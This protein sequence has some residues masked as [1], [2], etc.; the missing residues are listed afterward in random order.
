LNVAAPLP[1]SVERQVDR[2]LAEGSTKGATRLRPERRPYWRSVA[3]SGGAAAAATLIA[4]FLLF[5][6]AEGP[7]TVSA[8]EV[9]AKSANKL[10]QR[11]TSGVELLEYQLRLDGVPREMMPDHID[12][13]YRVRQ[14]I[15]HDTPGRFVITTHGPDGQ[16]VHGVAQD[17]VSHRR[18][19]SVRVDDRPFRFEFTVPEAAAMSLPEMERL[20]MEASVTMMQ[21]SGNQDLKVLDS[22]AGR[23]YRIEVPKV[24]STTPNAMWDLSEARVIVDA[25]DYHLVEFAVKGTFLKQPY[26]FSY[27]LI[28]RTIAQQAAVSTSEFE[29]PA[30]AGAIVIRGEG[31]AIPVRDALVLAL[32]ELASARQ[33]RPRQARQ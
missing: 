7:T 28:S 22:S 14:L 8:A 29:L 1:L 32:R 9:L 27:E 33:A 31:S 10:A 30:V 25:T 16:L 6:M 15:D 12:G 21:A 24:S 26:S 23:Q 5:P 19:L 4:V 11:V 13:S 3:W 20:H 18:V 2:A 17:P